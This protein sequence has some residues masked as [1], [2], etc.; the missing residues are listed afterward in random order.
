MD[1]TVTH[2]ATLIVEMES[3]VDTTRFVH[4]ASMTS[5]DSNVQHNAETATETRVI[6]PTAHAPMDVTTDITHRIAHLHANTLGVKH[7]T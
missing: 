2:H 7:V 5:G 3:V 4:R 6:I 1:S